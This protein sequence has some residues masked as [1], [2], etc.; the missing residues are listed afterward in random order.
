[1][2]EARDYYVSM[3]RDKRYALMAG[4]FATRDEALLMVDPVRKEAARHDPF[5]DFD[6]FGTC[7]LPQRAENKDGW[8]NVWV[9]AK[10]RTITV[11]RPHSNPEAK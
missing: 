9:G 1:M 11:S 10:P 4:P 6:M 8:L 7:S 5:C 3:V 2:N